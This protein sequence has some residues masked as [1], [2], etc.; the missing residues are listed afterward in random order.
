VKSTTSAKFNASTQANILLRIDPKYANQQLRKTVVFLDGTSNILKI[1]DLVSQEEFAEAQNAKA[2]IRGSEELIEDI[3]K[4][5]LNFDLLVATVDTM[6]KLAKFSRI[7]GP[8][9]LI[10]P[11]K[12][13]AVMTKSLTRVSC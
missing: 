12:T 2:D 3:S 9:E 5:I 8:K 1:T 6:P 13:E 11:L 7:L 4:G 10:P